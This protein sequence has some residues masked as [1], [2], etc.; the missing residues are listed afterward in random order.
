MARTVEDVLARRTR[1]LLLNAKASVAAA[2]KVA[3]ILA[4]ELG[5]DQAWQEGQVAEFEA[6][7]PG[8]MLT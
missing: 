7:A 4:A 6:L 1:S 2:P 8:Y 5:H 3:E